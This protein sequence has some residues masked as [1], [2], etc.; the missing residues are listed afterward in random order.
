MSSITPSAPAGSSVGLL[1]PPVVLGREVELPPPSPAP[2]DTPGPPRGRLSRFLRGKE[3]DP[4]WVRPALLT[5]LTLTAVLYLVDLGASGWGNSFYSAA[6]QAGTKSW[7]A[8]FFGSSDSSNFITVDK[9]PAALWVMEISARIFGV[10]SW[11]I[12]A[13]QALEGVATVGLVYLTVRRWFSAQAALLAG[14]ALAL[15]PVAALM[16]RFNNPDA[17]LALLL[18][19]SMYAMVR[20]L[21]RAQTKW[22]VLAGTLVGFGFITKMMQAFL[23]IPVLVIVYLL[24]APTGWWRRVGQTAV[25]GVT[26]V[27]AAG[28]WVAAVALTPAADRPYVGGSQNNS[29]LNLIFGYN[30]FG[31]LSGNESG[32]VGGS[33]TTGS[34]WGPTGLTRLFN[35]S[36]GNMMSWLLPGALVMGAVL[37]IVTIRARRT[38]RERAAL[39]LFGGTLAGIGL[40]ISLAHG[41]IHPYY[42]VAL[43]APLA[44][45]VGIATMAL[46][47]RRATW[48]GR[49]GLAVGLIA[50]TAWSFA[51]L[52][53][54]PQWF[55]ALRVLVLVA[56]ALGAVAIMALPW[57]R[58]TPLLA[59]G[60][61]AGL[62]FT[63]A[64]AAPLFSTVATAA[65]AHSGAIPSVTPTA[66]GGF[67]FGGGG[68]GGF[69][70]AGAGG[71]RTGG[72]GFP[73]FGGSRSGTRPPGGFGGGGFAG[74]APAGGVGQ[75]TRPTGGGFGAG[76]TGG[77]GGILNASTSNAALTKLLRADAG[78]YTWV[79]ATVSSNSASGYQLAS[80]DPVM[81]IGG[82]NGTDPAP[83]LSQ[84]EKYVSEGKIHYFISGGGGLG[85]G[86]GFGGGTSSGDVASSITSWVE[87]HFT[88]QTV[89]GTTVYNL[90]TSSVSS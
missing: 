89:G 18:T 55:P 72:G 52:N 53:R 54:T 4:V 24:A 68:P 79:A 41:I 39:L 83:S 76:R 40:T 19:G 85:G 81:A 49:S 90:T 51:L 88:A 30:G 63:A 66:S 50:T 22:L 23:I 62:G 28:W 8:F 11:S 13:P 36:F 84:F 75:G 25:L 46:W 29:I 37:L 31:R 7:K 10:N 82:F 35:D 47:E 58:R 26:T 34:M 12:L 5:L 44:G 77:G 43:A 78:Q 33:G 27:V 86:G 61:V 60:L 70:R 2:P 20:A 15:T 38:D 65:V 80:D 57:M 42:T 45:L 73:G 67:G 69:G 59:A 6:V 9:P 3:H 87:S 1:E 17:L 32:S 16:F 56:G 21:E 71:T 14:V 48:V 74:G 64:L